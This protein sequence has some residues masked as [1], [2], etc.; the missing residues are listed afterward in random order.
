[1]ITWFWGIWMFHENLKTFTYCHVLKISLPWEWNSSLCRADWQRSSRYVPG[2]SSIFLFHP[3]HNSTSKVISHAFVSPYSVNCWAAT[4]YL[5]MFAKCVRDFHSFLFFFYLNQPLQ[6]NHWD[7]T[8][9]LVYNP[10]RIVYL[11]E[12]GTDCLAR[13]FELIIA[14]VLRANSC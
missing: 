10:E 14:V 11:W 12:K 4:N 1:M 9:S 7:V 13:A 5:W 6:A 3:S 2:S 8:C